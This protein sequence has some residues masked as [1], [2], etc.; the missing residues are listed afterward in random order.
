VIDEAVMKEEKRDRRMWRVWSWTR[1]SNGL[2]PNAKGE[3]LATLTEA[4]KSM[5]VH[6]VLLQ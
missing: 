3:M 5:T 1:D 2:P 4:E 6:C